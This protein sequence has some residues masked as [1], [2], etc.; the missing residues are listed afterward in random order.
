MGHQDLTRLSRV[1]SHA[2]RHA[3]AQYGLVLDPGGWTPVEDLV[4]ALR[5]HRAEWSGLVTSDL[6]RL[7]ATADKPR[8]EMRDGR[9]RARYG[10]SLPDK[11]ARVPTEPPVRLFHGTTSG[12]V[13]GILREG[14]RPMRRQY[15]HLSLDE[16][17]ARRVGA[18]RAGTPVVLLVRA[19]DAHAAG[20]RFYLGYDGIWLADHVPPAYITAPERV[21]PSAPHEP[22]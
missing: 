14:L 21:A 19:A 16:A 17:T 3:P 1:I 12:A 8:F 10:H 7:I 18:R 2:L 15:V 5:G 13:P 11:I 9:I 22:R 6:D 20:V 4:A